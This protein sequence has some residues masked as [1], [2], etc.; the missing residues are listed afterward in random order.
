MTYVRLYW[1]GSENLGFPQHRSYQEQEALEGK[2]DRNQSGK[3]HWLEDRQLQFTDFARNPPTH[4]AWVPSRLTVTVHCRHKS[5]YSRYIDYR[6]SHLKFHPCIQH[7]NNTTK[8]PKLQLQ[9]KCT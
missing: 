9:I 2:R 6:H 4:C 7:S 5:Y 8:L 1:I 3:K